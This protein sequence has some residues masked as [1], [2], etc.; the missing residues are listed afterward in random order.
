[1]YYFTFD[2]TNA[3]DYIK[4]LDDYSLVDSE[5]IKQILEKHMEEQIENWIEN[6]NDY[7]EDYLKEDYKFW[8]KIDKAALEAERSQAA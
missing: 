4:N 2:F 6:I 8:K 7:P 3:V 5:K 1:M